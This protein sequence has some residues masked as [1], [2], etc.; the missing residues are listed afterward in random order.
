MSVTH[1]G[2]KLLNAPTRDCFG[3]V[4]VA[5]RVDG[6]RVTECEVAAIM[7]RARHDAAH[8]QSSEHR[9]CCLVNEPGVV[10]A[11]VDIDNHV[12][13]CRALRGKG[14]D[15]RPEVHIIA[16]STGELD[17][18]RVSW[19]CKPKR[20]VSIGHCWRRY[21][22]IQPDVNDAPRGTNRLAVRY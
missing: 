10:V 13:T 3:D 7:A 12:L 21:A 17:C 19:I 18:F 20:V 16:T 11:K 6:S 22:R 14:I 4:D 1:P 9:R 5:F 8:S 2:S 15:I